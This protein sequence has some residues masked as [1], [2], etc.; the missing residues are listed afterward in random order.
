M[1]TTG[2]QTGTEV[3]CTTTIPGAVA[4][5]LQWLTPKALKVG[6]VSNFP[7]VRLAEWAKLCKGYPEQDVH[8]KTA[9][10][11]EQ[12]FVHLTLWA[13]ILTGACLLSQ[14]NSNK[15]YQENTAKLIFMYLLHKFSCL[16]TFTA[17][18]NWKCQWLAC[19]Y[20]NIS[21]CIWGPLPS[22]SH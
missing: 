8:F 22:P 4:P 16:K 2:L 3:V 10:H 1:N 18:V 9:V 12:L 17:K 14:G 5:V 15:E 20:M 7:G 13:T 19:A 21:R 6:A 11:P